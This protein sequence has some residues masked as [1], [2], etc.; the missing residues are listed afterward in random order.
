VRD[1]GLDKCSLDEMIAPLYGLPG[2]VV[3]GAWHN[4]SNSEGLLP[5]PGTHGRV[6]VLSD[7]HGN[8]PALEAVLADVND[9][10][11]DLVV[12]CGDLTWGPEP[13]R[14]IDIVRSR[15]DSTV[16]IRG[17]AD[18]AIIELANGTRQPRRPRDAW[19]RDRHSRTGVDF[20][21]EFLFA[22]VVDVTG[23]GPVRFCHGSPRS[24]IEVITPGTPQH[25]LS[26]IADT[27][28]ERVLVSGHTHLQ[29]DRRVGGLRSVNPGSVG[30]P[31]HDG[32]PGTAYWALLGP[33]VQLR[34]TSYDVDE[35]V[36]SC[37]ATGDPLA[38][39]IVDLL[40]SPP[41]AA[42]V[43]RDAEAKVFSD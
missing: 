31:Y 12:F 18:R 7:V 38:S 28:G 26:E 32:P 24:D 37:V 6:A 41:G 2:V 29:F 9:A 40:M 36:R 27:I 19:M 42:E 30:V 22:A 10:G 3:S 33:D 35:A 1:E 21:S 17:N 8:V 25:R 20:L 43:I 16:F 15:I 11:V 5:S 14:T 4:R 13:E 39:I 23:L 34:R